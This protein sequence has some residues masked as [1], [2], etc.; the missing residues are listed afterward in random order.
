MNIKLKTEATFD[1]AHSLENYEGKC[2]NLHGHTWKVIVEIKGNSRQVKK[3]GIL[4]DFTNLK[5]EVKKFDHK[6][7]NEI[8]NFN[9]TSENLACY[10]VSKFHSENPD[11][12]FKVRVYESPKSYAEAKN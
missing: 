12:K 10:L 7:L 4:W 8:C 1:A 3:N 5:K 6:L 11:L 9:P 2:A